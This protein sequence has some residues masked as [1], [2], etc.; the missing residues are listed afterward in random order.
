MHERHLYRTSAFHWHLG[1]HARVEDLGSGK[2]LVRQDVLRLSGTRCARSAC[3][4][5]M[6]KWRPEKTTCALG[7]SALHQ[8]DGR[9]HS[10]LEG[11]EEGAEEKKVDRRH[12]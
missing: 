7:R 4:F 2:D 10:T 3:A 12:Q 8:E 6:R 5:E 9:R 1:P 11:E